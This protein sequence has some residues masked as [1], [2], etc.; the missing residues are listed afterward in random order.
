MKKLT[1][2]EAAFCENYIDSNCN[3]T[4]AYRK[5]YDA[6]GMSQASVHHEAS[7]LLAKPKITQ[8][9]NDLRVAHGKKYRID[10]EYLTHELLKA[11]EIA[12][13]KNN[14]SNIRQTVM[15]IAK[16]HGL[17]I[18]KQDV[19]TNHNFQVMKGVTIDGKALDFDVG[20]GKQIDYSGT[21]NEMQVIDIEP[22]KELTDI[23]NPQD[24]ALDCVPSPVP[25]SKRQ[26]K[27]NTPI[28]SNPLELQENNN[29]QD[30]ISDLY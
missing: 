7:I 3:A 19:N 26:A 6:K 11:L 8:R 15:D 30:D 24:I 18:E 9:I 25:P 27:D 21:Q 13:S 10:R 29:E 12:K 20:N 22:D 5:S 1:E 16:L 14:P 23:R 17:V 4:A 2:K 28:P